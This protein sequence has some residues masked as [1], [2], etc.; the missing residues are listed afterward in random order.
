MSSC[1]ENGL[2]G[3]LLTYAEPD[4]ERAALGGLG[5]HLPAIG[6]RAGEDYTEVTMAIA[7]SWPWEIGHRQPDV[8]T[9]VFQ[10]GTV[11]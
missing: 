3:S 5:G 10:P 1:T 11:L 7:P 9:G 4:H 6:S 2:P 8:N